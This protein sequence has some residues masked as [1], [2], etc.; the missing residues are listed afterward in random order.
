MALGS[1]CTDYVV[2]KSLRTARGLSA[3]ALA[4]AVGLSLLVGPAAFASGAQ[5]GQVPRPALQKD[6]P[7]AV[8]VPVG[9]ITGTSGAKPS[10]TVGLLAKGSA[11]Q[12]G[13]SVV[14]LYK[15]HGFTQA[16]NGTQVFSTRTY[17]VT[18][19]ERNHDHSATRTDIVLWLQTR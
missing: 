5:G 9:I 2:M 15:S 3:T 11:A 19:V 10:E 6:W 16:A 8:P 17:R 18:V 14:A 4:G 13:H 1:R 12:V 7:A